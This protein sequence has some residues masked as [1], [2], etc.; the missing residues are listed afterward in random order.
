MVEQ[1]HVPS[2]GTHMDICL[3]D[4]EINEAKLFLKTHN[5][6][7]K[8]FIYLNIGGSVLYKQ[9]P[10]KKFILLS[11]TILQKTS[12]AIVLGGGPEDKSKSR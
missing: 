2:D 5:I 4:D 1:I 10:I 12:L 3:N 11:K 8:G 9:W 7:S 6:L